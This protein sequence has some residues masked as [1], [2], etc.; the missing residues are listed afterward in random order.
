[1]RNLPV[2][3]A[4]LGDDAAVRTR[5]LAQAHVT[6]HHPLSDAAVLGIGHLL[7]ACWAAPTRSAG[8]GIE[9]WVATA[10]PAFRFQPYPGRAS[11]YV[12]DT[13]Q[14][15]L[16]CFCAHADFEPPWS[17]PSTRATT[18]TPPARWWACWPAHAAAPAPARRWLA[19]A[20]AHRGAR[21]HRPG[22][23]AAWRCRW[24]ANPLPA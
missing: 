17:P 10:H 8:A 19:P 13:V 11:G 9:A 3:L 18:P 6:H 21:H 16:H 4:T 20:A 7:R 15:V 12:V 5:V 2:A 22:Q 23:C 24:T 14:T 1:M